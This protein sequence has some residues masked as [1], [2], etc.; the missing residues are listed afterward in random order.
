MPT[1]KKILP[2]HHPKHAPTPG[3]IRAA[4]RKLKKRQLEELDRAN[5]PRLAAREVD[6]KFPLYVP[7]RQNEPAVRRPIARIVNGLRCIL[8]FD[9]HGKLL[10]FHMEKYMD[11]GVAGRSTDHEDVIRD[12]ATLRQMVNGVTYQAVLVNPGSDDERLFPASELE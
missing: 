12:V 8:A 9:D 3:E 6:V 11:Q 5:P 7:I 2:Q 1:R 10:Q 4:C